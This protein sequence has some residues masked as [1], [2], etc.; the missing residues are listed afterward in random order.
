[1][2]P[3]NSH[4]PIRFYMGDLILDVNTL[5]MLFCFFKLLALVGKGLNR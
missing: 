1:M 3:E 5:Y 2:N 4:K